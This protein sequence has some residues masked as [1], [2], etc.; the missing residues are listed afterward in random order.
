MKPYGIKPLKGISGCRRSH[1]T[2]HRRRCLR[3]DKKSARFLAR[4]EDNE[5]GTEEVSD[6]LSDS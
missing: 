6:T 2:P 3:V 1:D 5:I 4:K